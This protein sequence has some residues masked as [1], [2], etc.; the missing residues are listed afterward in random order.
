MAQV[1][2]PGFKTWEIIL[3]PFAMAQVRTCATTH[4]ANCVAQVPN[5]RPESLMEMIVAQVFHSSTC[6]TFRGARL[7]LAPRRVAQVSIICSAAPSYRREK[8]REE[9]ER[10]SILKERKGNFDIL[11]EISCESERN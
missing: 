3:A 10:R 2:K 9:R 8:N 7:E 11:E 1:R 6:A 5:L 4:G